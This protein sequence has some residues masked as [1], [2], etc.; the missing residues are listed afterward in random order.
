MSAVLSEPIRVR[1]SCHPRANPV[2]RSRGARPHQIETARGRWGKA[3]Q[4]ATGGGW[5][6]WTS[7]HLVHLVRLLEEL[8]LALPAVR[9]QAHQGPGIVVARG[10]AAALC[11]GEQ[12]AVNNRSAPRQPAGKRQAFHQT[13]ASAPARGSS[14]ERGPS[15]RTLL[16]PQIYSAAGHVLSPLSL[17][18]RNRRGP[19][20]RGRGPSGTRGR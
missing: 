16:G 11:G 17:P 18:S 6:V 2:A 15:T 9:L 3:E 14:S 8:L 19:W 20:G 13:A 4:I 10:A 7:P 12:S 1:S 5:G